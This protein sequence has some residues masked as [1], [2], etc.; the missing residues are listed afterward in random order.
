MS[1][2]QRFRARYGPFANEA[3]FAIAVE[4]YIRCF[5][6]DDEYGEQRIQ[7]QLLATAEQRGL[8]LLGGQCGSCEQRSPDLRYDGH[9][10]PAC[11]RKA[12]ERDERE[13]AEQA[14]WQARYAAMSPEERKRIADQYLGIMEGLL[15]RD[16]Q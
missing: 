16:V 4:A 5:E 9:T 6:R 14:E 11:K 7:D 1:V 13:A 8:T 2:E 3:W 12:Q 15:S 10:C